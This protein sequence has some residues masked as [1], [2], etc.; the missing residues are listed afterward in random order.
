[1]K[2]ETDRTNYGLYGKLTP[3]TRHRMLRAGT[4]FATP[5]LPSYM[6]TDQALAAAASVL[7]TEYEAAGLHPDIIDSQIGDVLDQTGAEKAVVI[8]AANT[9][10]SDR[11]IPTSGFPVLDPQARRIHRRVVE[12]SLRTNPSG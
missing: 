12:R 5:E 3:R 7:F 1:M 9:L 10:L 11:K 2:R 4:I 8:L 6:N